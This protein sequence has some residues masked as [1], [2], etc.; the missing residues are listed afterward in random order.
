MQFTSAKNRATAETMQISTPQGAGQ[1]L[2]RSVRKPRRM[3]VIMK[4]RTEIPYS[5]NVHFTVYYSIRQRQKCQDDFRKITKLCLP[6]RI[7]LC[8]RRKFRKFFI[9]RASVFGKIAQ[10]R[11]FR[12]KNRRKRNNS[13]IF[14]R[15]RLS[16]F[17]GY[18]T[19]KYNQKAV[20]RENRKQI[21][22]KC[23]FLRFSGFSA[24]KSPRFCHARK[25]RPVFYSFCALTQNALSATI[26]SEPE[27]T[28][29]RFWI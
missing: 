3:P 15:V 25:I 23:G 4:R 6:R 5:A 22:K 26:S 14:I 7:P 19:M 2:A 24:A 21:P 8:K 16:A 17:R 18:V 20:F 13:P 9:V 28:E 11:P 12:P 10:I 27:Q 29:R 1:K